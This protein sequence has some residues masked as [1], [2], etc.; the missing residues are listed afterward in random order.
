MIFFNKKFNSCDKNI[1]FTVEKF[2]NGKEHF[3]DIKLTNTHRSVLMK[4]MKTQRPV[5]LPVTLFGHSKRPGF[6]PYAIEQ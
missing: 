5:L 2:L 1:Q 4:I 6:D 3:L